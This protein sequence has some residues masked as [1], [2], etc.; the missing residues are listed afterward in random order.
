MKRTSSANGN[1][2]SSKV[3]GD[4]RRHA[5]DV[6]AVGPM[7]EGAEPVAR[8][9]RSRPVDRLA[10]RLGARLGEPHAGGR[11][12]AR[13]PRRRPTRGPRRRMPGVGSSAIRGRAPAWSGSWPIGAAAASPRAARLAALAWARLRRRCLAAPR[14][15]SAARSSAAGSPASGSVVRAAVEGVAEDL[16]SAGSSASVAMDQRESTR[17]RAKECPVCALISTD[18]SRVRFQ[19]SE[20]SGYDRRRSNQGRFE[21]SDIG[22]QVQ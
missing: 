4:H 14:L 10:R 2:A 7:P 22:R 12:P 16:A 8:P 3:V 1:S 17:G 5:G 20:A 21:A 6:L 9:R 11:Q 13:R 18:A 19:H 15:G